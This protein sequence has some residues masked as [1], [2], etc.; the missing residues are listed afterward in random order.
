MD[1]LQQR[2]ASTLAEARELKMD[3]CWNANPM[4]KLTKPQCAE[5]TIAGVIPI[6][7]MEGNYGM[8]PRYICRCD[9]MIVSSKW[10]ELN[11]GVNQSIESRRREV[12]EELSVSPAKLSSWKVGGYTKAD[13]TKV[14]GYTAAVDADK[15]PVRAAGLEHYQET[16]DKLR[17]WTENPVPEYE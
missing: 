3:S 9:I 10:T 11:K 16:Q 4:D 12:V 6:D 13:G 7:E 17:V 14:K 2:T 1:L 8:P 15:Y 5:A